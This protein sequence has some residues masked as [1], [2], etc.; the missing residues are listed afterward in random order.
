MKSTTIFALIFVVAYGQD[1][2]AHRHLRRV[3]KPDETQ[4]F[5][6]IKEEV[7]TTKVNEIIYHNSSSLSSILLMNQI[8][9][10]SL[11]I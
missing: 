4:G 9:L 6:S 11:G 10:F 2:A 3:M 8:T 5:L 1:A 7:I